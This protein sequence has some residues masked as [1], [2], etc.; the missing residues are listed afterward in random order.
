[1]ITL[2]IDCFTVSTGKYQKFDTRRLPL[3]KKIKE[4]EYHSR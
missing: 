4:L 3:S 1:M 2:T